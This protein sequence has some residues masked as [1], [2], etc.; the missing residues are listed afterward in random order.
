MIYKN[1]L[2]YSKI[3]LAL[4]I[5]KQKE[6]NLHKLI[7]L[8]T[9]F[10]LFKDILDIEII[11]DASCSSFSE[12]KT[13]ILIY[14][15]EESCL[16]TE[17]SIYKA[18][19]IYLREINTNAYIKVNIKKG[20]PKLSGLGG[21]SSDAGLILL[22]LNNAFLNA[23]S[24]IQLFTIGLKVGSD[25]CFFLSSYNTA[26][27]YNTGELVYQIKNRS[28]LYFRYIK[29]KEL[30]IST[31]DAFIRLDRTNKT[32]LNLPER[33]EL[34]LQYEKDV[35]NWNFEN[36][37]SYLYKKPIIP[38]SEKERIYLTGAGPTWFIVGQK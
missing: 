11:T 29:P 37:F 27:I 6:N 10:P 26:I 3:N 14:G 17:S 9:L 36:D 24:E 4:Y 18:I 2:A 7:S 16:N 31:K 5:S 12:N 35:N 28:D 25:V 13:K 33:K 1:E 8:I 22:I 38:T 32:H 30:K 21:A 23:L 15:L 34:E 20:I 19:K